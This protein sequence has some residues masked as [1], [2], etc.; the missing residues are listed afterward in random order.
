[1][2]NPI[3]WDESGK[4]FYETG[5]EKGVL[6]VAEGG[7]YPK[8]VAWNGLINVAEKPSGAE[9]TPLYADNIKYLNLL[10]NED[11]AASVEAYY[12]PDEFAACDGSAEIVPGV[13]VGQQT[14]KK[15]G[16]SYVTKLG[17]DEDG[18]DHG[19][20]IHLIYGCL[21]APSEKAYGTVNESPEAIT[22]SWELSTT[23]VA[24]PG[25]KPTACVVID[26]TKLAPEKLA[27]LEAALYGAGEKEAY[28]PL[29]TELATMLA[30]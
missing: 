5:V 22:F 19:Y 15:F 28:L 11:F 6:Y 26:S 23:P 29:P 30:A 10:S 12:Y 13:T 2:P 17:N 25:L 16:M 3:V 20:K 27:V 9:P 7:A 1:M 24:V 21:A 18:T 14:R 8:G 4:R